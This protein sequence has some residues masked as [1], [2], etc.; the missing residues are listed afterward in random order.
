MADPVDRF[1][2]GTR[3]RFGS[4]DFICGQE[5]QGLEMLHVFSPPNLIGREKGLHAPPSDDFTNM[6][7][8]LDD[9]TE[10]LSGFYLPD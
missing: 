10:A 4:L 6:A 5:S 9:V 7:T 1:A 2:P 8:N 3:I